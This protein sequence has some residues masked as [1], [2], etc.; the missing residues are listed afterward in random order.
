MNEWIAFSL[1]TAQRLKG[2]AFGIILHDLRLVHAHTGAEGGPDG[3]VQERFPVVADGS[4]HKEYC[5]KH[6]LRTE[7]SNDSVGEIAMTR[8]MF[9]DD[10]RRCVLVI[11]NNV[12]RLN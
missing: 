5:I 7:H 9:K 6:L 3:T 4:S 11:E 1:F 10:Q 8:T 12:G 2:I